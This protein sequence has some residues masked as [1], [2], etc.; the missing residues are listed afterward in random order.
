MKKRTHKRGIQKKTLVDADPDASWERSA[1]GRERQDP[2]SAGQS[3][4][5]Q[6]LSGTPD[7]DS[8]SV[9]ELVE[10]GQ[11]YEAEV[12]SGV[13]NASDDTEKP[14]R[15]RE[16]PEDDVPEEYREEGEERDEVK[17]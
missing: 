4:D 9:D 2:H 10:E 7:A 3:G 11:F 5:L 13:E 17:E 16:V 1:A 12:V 15:T 6:G 8:E 14:L